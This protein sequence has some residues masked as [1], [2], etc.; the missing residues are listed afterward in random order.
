M[1][2]ELT[3]NRMSAIGPSKTM[4]HVTF[5]TLN[6]SVAAAI[7]SPESLGGVATGIGGLAAFAYIIVIRTRRKSVPGFKAG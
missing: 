3:E 4:L 7:A 2:N 6:A 1:E 5:W